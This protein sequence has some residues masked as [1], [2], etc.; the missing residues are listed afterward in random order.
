MLKGN[1]SLEIWKQCHSFTFYL[2]LVFTSVFF[3]TEM[4]N[5]LL[6][7]FYFSHFSLTFADR[8]QV[9][10]PK[11]FAN[12]DAEIRF[13]G[14]ALLLLWIVTIIYMTRDFFF[15]A[16]FTPKLL[17]STIS[18]AEIQKYSHLK[19]VVEENDES[20]TVAS[21]TIVRHRYSGD[22]CFNFSVHKLIVRYFCA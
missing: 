6:L 21:D 15:P 12:S 13:L 4:P 9:K 11:F 14:W 18:L 19:T 20:I 16:F 1:M 7:L 2:S 17:Q 5:S 3:K 22:S 10:V 8:A